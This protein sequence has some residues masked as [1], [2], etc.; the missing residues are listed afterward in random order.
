MEW[1][2][3]LTLHLSGPKGSIRDLAPAV[4]PGFTSETT[5]RTAAN[6]VAGSMIRTTG[7]ARDRQGIIKN[8]MDSTPSVNFECIAVR[9]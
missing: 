2:L 3:V 6:A 5:C 4:V 9:K 1:L 7:L 8:S